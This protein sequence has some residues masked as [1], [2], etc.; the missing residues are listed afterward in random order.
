MTRGMTEER[1]QM[2]RIREEVVGKVSENGASIGTFLSHGEP[3][4]VVDNKVTIGFPERYRF[5]MDVLKK[6]SRRIET[7]LEK[8]FGIELKVDFVLE[9]GEAFSAES[10]NS[11]HPVT[12]RVLELFGGETTN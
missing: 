5:Q 6:N 1:A 11:D 10:D 3:S 8:V 2:Q 12:Q 9:K 4:E 7:S